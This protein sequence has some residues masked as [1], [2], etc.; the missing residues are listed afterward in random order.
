[1]KP[2]AVPTIDELSLETVDTI[3]ASG[4]PGIVAASD[5]VGASDTQESVWKDSWY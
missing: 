2:Y 4:D 5:S 1:M 3:T